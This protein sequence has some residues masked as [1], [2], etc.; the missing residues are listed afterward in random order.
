MNNNRFEYSYRAPTQEQ[1]QE[2]PKRL[3][4]V[5]VL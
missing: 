1:R 4:V 3:A 2:I 5:G